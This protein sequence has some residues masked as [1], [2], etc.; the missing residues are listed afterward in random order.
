M[1]TYQRTINTSLKF[2]GIGLHTGKFSNI[3]LIPVKHNT[4][5][6]FKKNK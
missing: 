1:Y 6:I 5:I 2:S 4:G 3:K